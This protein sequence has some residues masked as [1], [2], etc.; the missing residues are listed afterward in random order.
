MNDGCGEFRVEGH[1][2]KKWQGD[3]ISLGRTSVA[4]LWSN[5]TSKRC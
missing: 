3:K 4:R 1:T 5:K 2:G